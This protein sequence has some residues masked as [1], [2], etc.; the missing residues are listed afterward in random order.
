MHNFDKV[1]NRMNS[2][3]VKWDR[4]EEVFQKADI[5]PLW[6][7]DMDFTS[8]KEVLDAIQKRLQHGIF[9]YT[10]IAEEL[11]SSVIHWNKTRHNWDIKREQILFD[12]S[13][14]SS[15]NILLH[16]LT[17]EKDNILMLSP[18]YYPFF[19]IVKTL[20]RVS[21]F[22]IMKVDHHHYQI[23]F[24]DLEK[25]M[26]KY[27]PKVMIFC[28]PHN[29]GG[30]VWNPNELIK[31]IALCKKYHVRIISDDI[32][33]DIIFTGYTYTPMASLNT[34]YKEQIYTLSAPT[35]VFNI[36]GIK[37][38]YVIIYDE[39]IRRLYQI[40]ANRRT[41]SSLNIFAMEATKAAYKHCA[42]WVDE[43]NAYLYKSYLMIQNGLKDTRFI[44]FQ[45]EGT[46][47]LWIDYT[48]LH[49]S[50]ADM[51]QILIGHGL[52]MQMGKQFGEAGKS[53]FRFNI[54]TQYAVLEDVVERLKLIDDIIK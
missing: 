5:I 33:K 47:L 21:I 16:I 45:S 54:A 25:K 35:K 43:L 53:Y 44:C 41:S 15:L 18:I 30:R 19:N 32:H 13:V 22:S 40:E 37:A 1:V 27:S 42:Y 29:P 14:L 17:K 31:V 26:I 12:D 20:K 28:N 6:V 46:Y 8:P 39:R 3:S 11:Y 49:V 51:K 4:R 34:Q 23:D 7:A 9:G 24:S 38:S 50:C 10:D 36:A 48:A 2:G 52:G